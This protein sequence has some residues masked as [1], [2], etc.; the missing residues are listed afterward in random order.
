M[1][2][3]LY[4]RADQSPSALKRFWSREL[5]IPIKNFKGVF[6]DKRTEGSKTFDYYKG[7]CSL[8]CGNV[9]IKK[10]LMNLSRLFCEKIVNKRV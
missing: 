10:R 6:V 5:K 7:V 4:I 1:R 8:R 2:C 3:E 9:A